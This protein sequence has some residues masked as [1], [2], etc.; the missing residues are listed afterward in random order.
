MITKF[1]LP[2]CSGITKEGGEAQGRGMPEVLAFR[3]WH[4]IK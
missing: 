4:V 2:F 3:A 1:E